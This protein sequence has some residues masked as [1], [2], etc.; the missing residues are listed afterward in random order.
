MGQITQFKNSVEEKGKVKDEDKIFKK[1]IVTKNEIRERKVICSDIDGVLAD[2]SKSF[3]DFINEIKKTNYSVKN[4]TC[5]Q[6]HKALGIE[7]EEEEHLMKMFIERGKIK[8]L[9][10][11]QHAKNCIKE[12]SNIVTIYAIT[13][14]Q[15]ELYNDTMFWIRKNFSYYITDVFF[16][17]EKFKTKSSACLYLNALLLVEDSPFYSLEVAEKGIKVL[18]F[19]YSYNRDAKHKNI[20]RVFG[21][22]E[23]ATE[24]IKEILKKSC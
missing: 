3:L 12:L 1:R 23:E 21:G 24:I 7:R 5:W 17:G 15:I 22:W 14:R 19:D 4:L 2:Y 6:I 16:V 18:L 8:E 9:P 13:S 20:I 11:I 10:T